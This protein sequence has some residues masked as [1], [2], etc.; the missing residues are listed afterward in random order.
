M[1]RQALRLPV[2][3]GEDRGELRI[4]GDPETLAL[5]RALAASLIS[6]PAGRPVARLLAERL[7]SVDDQVTRERAI[8][9]AL[10]PPIATLSEAGVTQLRWNAVAREEALREFGALTAAEIAEQRGAQ[11][12]N[13]HVTVSRWISGGRAFAVETPAGRRIPAFQLRD[14]APRPVIAR[15]LS[16]LAGSLEGWELLLWFTASN[17]WLDGARPVDLLDEDPDAVVVA[18]AEQAAASLD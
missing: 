13:P 17:G 6:G 18:A 16:A 8:V 15:V 9:D 11:T 12:T 7:A 14:G 10:L 3:A 1:N 4:S 2:V 5:V